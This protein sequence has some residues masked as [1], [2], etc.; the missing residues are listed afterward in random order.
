MKLLKRSIIFLLI[1]TII[2]AFGGCAAKTKN[3]DIKNEAKTETK[4]TYPLTVKDSN[5]D[6]VTIDKEPKRV[7]SV[8]P[9]IT[10]TV[11]ALGKGDELVG[12][13]SYCDYPKKAKK[14]QDIGSITDPNV[15]KIIALKPEV[16]IAAT[17]F[18]AAVEKKLKDLGIKVVVIY[19]AN[20]FNGVYNGI[21]T[22]GKILNAK[23][24]AAELVAGMKTKVNSIVDKI[25][26]AKKP[27]VYYVISFGKSGDYTATGETFIAQMINMA[28]GENIAKD[29]KGWAY[30][31]EKLIQ[32]NPDIVIVSKMYNTKAQ[33]IKADGYKKLKAVAKGKVLEIDNNLLD[34]QGPR[35]AD[36][37]E[38]M[39]KLLHPDLFK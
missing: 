16:V 11:F 20:D 4:T 31:K 13:S 22:I 9:S 28:G 29:A 36:G 14:V 3:K 25:K 2:M 35:I 10:E 21:D 39:A 5:G 23:K 27:T 19:D 34:R 15:E 32:K 24:K 38:E 30:S 1:M 37:L 6:E 26:D 18:K 33:F 17:H 8:A 12:R 7:V